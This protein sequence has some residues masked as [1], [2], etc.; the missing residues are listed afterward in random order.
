M[1]L[2]GKLGRLERSAREDLASFLLE[3]GSR[4]YYNPISG[5][6][7]LHGCACLHAQGDA[8]PFPDPPETLKALTRAKD[9][10]A[11]L[12]Q[13]CPTKTFSLFPYE[14]EALIERGELVPRSLVVGYELGERI[15]DL[16][17]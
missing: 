15:P 1:G 17:E 14:E 7:F 10:R 4:Y 6:I 13:V 16:S 9:R 3:D 5:E 8:E 2:R 12:E 11:A